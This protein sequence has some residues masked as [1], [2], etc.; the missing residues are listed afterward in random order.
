MVLVVK[1]AA[2]QH[3]LLGDIHQSLT[4][5]HLYQEIRLTVNKRYY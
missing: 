2:G 5:T 4:G 1:N 3:Y